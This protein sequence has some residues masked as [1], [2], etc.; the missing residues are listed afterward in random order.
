MISFVE[1]SLSDKIIVVENRLV[2]LRVRFG[3]RM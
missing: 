1:Q 3:G 2:V